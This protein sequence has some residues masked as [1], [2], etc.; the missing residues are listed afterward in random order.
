VRIA[1]IAGFAAAGVIA[2]LAGV[3]MRSHDVLGIDPKERL[4][5][6]EAI[7]SSPEDARKLVVFE[8]LGLNLTGGAVA[9][10]TPAARGVLFAASLDDC[11]S[12][13]ADRFGSTP[14]R[15]HAFSLVPAWN[16]IAT[17]LLH[18]DPAL[19]SAVMDATWHLACDKTVE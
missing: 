19:Q 8:T 15:L 4:K 11:T 18:A 10:D 3:W 14:D 13:A 6:W 2:L 16:K 17:A 5:R 9:T 1:R 7:G 12:L